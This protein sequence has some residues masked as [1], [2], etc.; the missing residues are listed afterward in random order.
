MKHPH[1]LLFAVATLALSVTSAHAQSIDEFDG[2]IAETSA[3]FTFDDS[4]IFGGERDFPG[5]TNA[6]ITFTGGQMVFNAINGIVN[7]QL[8]YDGNDNDPDLNFG[9]GGVDLTE[10]G[11]DSFQVFI[12]AFTTVNA[13]F[14]ITIFEDISNSRRSGTSPNF[15]YS[16]RKE[17]KKNYVS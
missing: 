2:E 3:P 16:G 4:D 11:A 12:S 9:L 5:A 7:D 1:T 13:S 6:T 15:A 14:S 17:N 10:N 8:Y